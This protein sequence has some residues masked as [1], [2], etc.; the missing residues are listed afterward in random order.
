MALGVNVE[1]GGFRK[2]C[3][4]EEKVMGDWKDSKW[5][6]SFQESI[7]RLS[8]SCAFLGPTKG[9]DTQQDPFYR[10]DHFSPFSLPK[11]TSSQDLSTSPQLGYTHLNIFG[12]LFILSQF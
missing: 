6:E 12:Y 3:V 5:L 4:W 2:I 1:N 8:L 10:W 11:T 7:K 9:V